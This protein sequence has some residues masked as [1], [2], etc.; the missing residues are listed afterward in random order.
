MSFWKTLFGGKSAAHSTA[1]KTS[2]PEAY[3][4][5]TIR[6]APFKADAQYQAA[7]FIEKEIAGVR[8]E[9]HFIRADFFASYDDAVTFSLTKARQIIDLQGDRVF[10]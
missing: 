9:H 4:G 7:G 8:K 10:D 1:A 6:A 3:N 5:F 2:P